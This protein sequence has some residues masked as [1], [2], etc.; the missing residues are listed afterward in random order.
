MDLTIGAFCRS[1]SGQAKT[2]G[3]PY[4][5]SIDVFKTR[6]PP[7]RVKIRAF[8]QNS[9]TL[10]RSRRY[11]PFVEPFFSS[12]L[13]LGLLGQTAFLVGFCPVFW[14]KRD[15]YI[16]SIGRRARTV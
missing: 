13:N 10:C 8:L 7:V 4:L 3:V 15:D 12:F 2:C 5:G 14:G 9:T 6:M 1:S 16:K 11:S